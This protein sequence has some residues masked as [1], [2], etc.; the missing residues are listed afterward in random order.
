MEF[1]AVVIIIG[2][3]VFVVRKVKRNSEA[4]EYVRIMANQRAIEEL[5]TSGACC[6]NCGNHT[7][8][9]EGLPN[10]CRLWEKR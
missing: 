5:K 9:C 10:P 2:V 3:I 7:R 8:N 6:E 1:F 4:N